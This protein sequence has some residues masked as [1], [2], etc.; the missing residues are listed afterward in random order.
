MDI[1]ICTFMINVAT[2]HS[3]S[4]GEVQYQRLGMSDVD[5]WLSPE[6]WPYLHSL[7]VSH[8]RLNPLWQVKCIF[9]RHEGMFVLVQLKQSDA[10][11]H[12]HSLRAGQQAMLPANLHLITHL[13]LWP[14]FHLMNHYLNYFW[15]QGKASYQYHVTSGDVHV[16]WDWLFTPGGGAA[17]GRRA[18]C[19]AIAELRWHAVE[20]R[21]AQRL[22][23][24]DALRC[25]YRH[26]LTTQ[27]L[28]ITGDDNGEEVDNKERSS[29]SLQA[30]VHLS[31]FHACNNSFMCLSLLWGAGFC[32]C[33]LWNPASR[34]SW[35]VLT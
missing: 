3:P 22:R 23:P 9:M 24:L 16:G 29:S 2:Q 13:L 30:L 12:K 14:F 33:T 5:L 32:K 4:S 19:G 20:P 1:L 10:K 8:T 31:S 7:G 25:S 26:P 17:A 27:L 35:S 6:S 28:G 15:S 21:V 11:N 18:G 34:L